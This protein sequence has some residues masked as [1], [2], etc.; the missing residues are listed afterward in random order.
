M[1]KDLQKLVNEFSTVCVRRKLK[2]N[3]SKSKVM[4]FE[5][6]KSE[7]IQFADQYRMRVES[8]KQCKIMMNEQIMEEVNEFKYLGS[9]LCKYGSM[10]GEIR[11][12]ALQGR[13]GVRSLGRMMRERRVSKEVK[14]ALRDSII[15]LTLTCASE[16]WTWNK[17]QRSKIQ[18]VE[19]SY[20][21]GGCGVNRMDG[22]SNENV[23]RRLGMATKGE[24]MGC[25][26]V[27]MVKHSTL[28]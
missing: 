13:K 15:I 28:R 3:V 5:R 6:R 11:E 14:K 20:L 24:G 7:I 23:Y 2:V 26:V 4:V 9:V 18:A 22:E 21:R 25:G 1:K 19:M 10:E 16:T 27:E 12:R 8:Q 17:C